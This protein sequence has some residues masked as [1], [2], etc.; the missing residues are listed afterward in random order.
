MSKHKHRR[1]TDKET[2]I[3]PRPDFW[4]AH[5]AFGHS[6][7]KLLQL[8]ERGIL[9]VQ[10]KPIRVLS[11]EGHP[12]FRERLATII[13][14]QQD[15]LLVAQAA[16]AVEAM[17]EFRRYRP[18]ITLM[19]VRLPIPRPT[20]RGRLGKPPGHNRRLAAPLIITN[21]TRT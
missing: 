4:I 7:N 9:M 8:R 10:D 1:D 5:R 13:G 6:S 17:A 21:R 2:R 14:S 20:P 16:N 19:D 12:V 3:T 18:D 15:M 11:V